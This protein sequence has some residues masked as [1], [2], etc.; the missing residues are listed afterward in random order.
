MDNLMQADVFFFISSLGFVVLAIL[1]AIFLFYLIRGMKTL[2]RIIDKAEDD[3]EK[4]GDVTKEMVEEMK[5]SYI[6]NFLFGKK[7]RKKT[8]N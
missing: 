3:I 2:S 5:E 1:L 4:I 8:T 7:K 6:F